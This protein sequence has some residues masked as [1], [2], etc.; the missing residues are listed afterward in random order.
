MSFRPPKRLAVLFSGTG[1]NFQAILQAC[2]EGQ[3]AGTVV[4]ALTNRPGAA[5]VVYAEQAGIPCEVV[6]HTAY[7][8]RASFDQAMIERIDAF[9][10]DV[11]ILAG[12]M[13][14]LTDDFVRHYSGRLLN[15]HPSLLPLYPG[16]NTHQRALEAGDRTHGAS[17]HFVTEDL[18][19]GPVI[20]QAEIPILPGD[21]PE[22]LAA[23]LIRQEHILY[24]QVLN[25]LCDDRLELRDNRVYLDGQCLQG[26]VPAINRLIPT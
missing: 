24:P 12:F 23:R 20:A 11:I 18:D 10:P 25:W 21:T 2:Q 14:I 13:R 22:G 7:E 1:S 3:V 19:G 15:I 9:Q 16:L 5:G 4:V 26:R 17:V 8:D 6:D